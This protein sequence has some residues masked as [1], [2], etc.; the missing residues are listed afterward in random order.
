MTN[1]D[2]RSVVAALGCIT[3]LCAEQSLARP[4][5]TTAEGDQPSMEKTMNMI[6]NRQQFQ[7]ADPEQKVMALASEMA[8][9]LDNYRGGHWYAEVYPASKRSGILFGDIAISDHFEGQDRELDLLGQ[10]LDRLITEWKPIH[11]KAERLAEDRIAQA[12]EEGV[13]PYDGPLND[14]EMSRF[15]QISHR[16]GAEAAIK[17]ENELCTQIDKINKRIRAMKPLTFAGLSVWAK[18]TRFDC[19]SLEDQETPL[20]EVDWE[21]ECLIRLLNEIDRLAGIGVAQVG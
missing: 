17:A 16:I 6:A 9:E 15:W 12:K 7:S 11:D 5:P 20:K 10:E 13:S 19:L 4:I 2:R 14:A 18:A 8:A 21:K 1:I 3:G